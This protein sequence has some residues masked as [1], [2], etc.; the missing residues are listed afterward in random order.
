MNRTNILLVVL[1]LAC[2]ANAQDS[3]RSGSQAD[4]TPPSQVLGAGEG[5]EDLAGLLASGWD[6]INTSDDP[7]GATNPDW[8]QGNPVVFNAH[9]GPDDSYAVS[10]FNA[11]GGSQISNWLLVPRIGE[12]G[13][14]FFYTRTV[15]GNTFP[16]RMQ[17]RFSAVSGT[18][19]GTDPGTVGDY[20]ILLLDINPNLDMGG[21]PDDWAEF[22]VHP[23]A[24]GRLAFRYFVDV[25]A[26]PVGSNSN[27]IGVDSLTVTI[28]DAPPPAIPTLSVFG[29]L[30]LAL[31]LLVATLLVKRK[32]SF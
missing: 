12:L 26:G 2:A 1:I 24:T 7:G 3:A 11:T 17:V 14:A 27:F 29:L 25:D 5:F 19:V 28:I 23:G 30:L 15:S 16:D 20:D 18:N 9:I 8:F 21:Y 4:T 13:S 6:T 22:I 31:L 10:N 32:N